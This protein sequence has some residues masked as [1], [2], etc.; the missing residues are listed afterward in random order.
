MNSKHWLD[1]LLV[2]RTF[3][4]TVHSI[5]HAIRTDICALRTKTPYEIVISSGDYRNTVSVVHHL[6]VVLLTKGTL[7]ETH[8]ALPSC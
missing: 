1:D 6:S 8:T 7:D 4:I 2:R 3:L 5:K